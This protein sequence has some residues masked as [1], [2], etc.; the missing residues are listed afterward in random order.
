MEITVVGTRYNIFLNIIFRPNCL[1][2]FQGRQSGLAHRHHHPKGT[3]RIC[4]EL[5]GF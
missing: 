1:L 2:L 4:L 3:H 5:S